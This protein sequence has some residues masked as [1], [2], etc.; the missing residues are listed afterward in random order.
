MGKK[1]DEVLL[2]IDMLNDFTLKGAP[3]EVPD[4]SR[5]LP[6]IKRQIKAAHKSGIP[7]IF[8]N[9]SHDP[10]DREFKVWPRHAVKGTRGAQVVDEIAPTVKDLIIEKNT[11][12][13]FYNTKLESIL[14]DLRV[15][16]IKICGCI[17]NIC[18]LYIAF[19]ATL[20]GYNVEVIE[21]CVA[22][23]NEEDHYFAMKQLENVIG[24]KVIRRKK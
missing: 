10:N 21:D 8:I 4:N 17:S 6:N 2:I 11:L 18:V 20:R 7:V 22:A 9:D 5:I 3:L 24:A 14:K 16:K 23:L 15:K 19:D 13:G 12:S 1:P